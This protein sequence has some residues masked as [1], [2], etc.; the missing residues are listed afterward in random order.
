MLGDAV[1]KD[2]ALAADLRAVTEEMAQQSS[3]FLLAVREIAAGV[4][5]ES[6]VP[7]LLLALTQIVQ[8]GAKLGC[9]ADVVPSQRFE[10]DNGPDP[11]LDP[12]RAGLERCLHGIDEYVYVAEPLYSP[13]VVGGRISDDVAEVMAGL[14]HGLRHFQSGQFD[15]A[16]WWWQFSYVS[17]WADPAFEACRALQ[18]ILSHLRLDVDNDVAAA[19]AFD[20]LHAE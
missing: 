1:D 15:E 5:P 10:P 11:D 20:A 7:M 14:A 12:V 16:L 2:A 4:R 8:A 3:Q 9:M 6:T 17:S 18:S 13:E 19:A